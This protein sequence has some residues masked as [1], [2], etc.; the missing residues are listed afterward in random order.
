MD[1]N[2]ANVQVIG[3]SMMMKK[4]QNTILH[5]MIDVR[6]VM[7]G[8]IVMVDVYVIWQWQRE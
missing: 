4:K 8:F 1:Q 7:R 5:A 3:A 2:V 6:R